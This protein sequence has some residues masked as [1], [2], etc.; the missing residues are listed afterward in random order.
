MRLPIIL[1]IISIILG[2]RNHVPLTLQHSQQPLMDMLPESL[3]T[4]EE[5]EV[6]RG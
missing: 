4:R 1:T 6:Q 5:T 2:H 3:L